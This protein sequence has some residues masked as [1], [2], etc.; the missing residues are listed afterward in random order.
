MFGL[1]TISVV[2]FATGRTLFLQT[3]RGVSAKCTTMSK[4]GSVLACSK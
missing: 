2:P 1:F 3:G 4:S